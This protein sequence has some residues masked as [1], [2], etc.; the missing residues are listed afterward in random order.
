MTGAFTACASGVVLVDNGVSRCRVVAN[1]GAPPAVEFGARE[2]AKYLGKATGAKVEAGTRRADGDGLCQVEVRV[3]ASLPEESYAIDVDGKDV[4]VRGADARGVL[5]G[6]YELLKRWAGMRW[7]APGEDGEYCVLGGNTVEIPVGKY[8][9]GPDLK[10]RTYSIAT[11]EDFLWC[12]RNNMQANLSWRNFSKDGTSPRDRRLMEL[13]VYGQGRSGHCLTR[14]LCH[15]SEDPKK[16]F[17]EHPEYFCLVKGKRVLSGLACYGPNP[18]TSN[19]EVLDRMAETVLMILDH[20]HGNEAA[21]VTIGNDDSMQWCECE[22]CKAL[23]PAET[24]S[25]GKRRRADR[26]WRMVNEIARRVWAKRP[27]A[28]LGGWAYQDFWKP[29][30]KVKPDSRLSLVIS[31]NNQ[32]WRHSI[33][34]PECDVNRDLAA[35]YRMWKPLKMRLV[36]NRNEFHC[37]GCPGG[38]FSPVERTLAGNFAQSEALRC[39]GHSFAGQGPFPDPLPW[40]AKSPDRYP[41]YGGKNMRWWACWQAHY[42]AARLMWD[43]S[44]DFAAELEEANSLMYGS[45]WQGGMKEFR[46]TLVKAFYATPGCQRWPDS[47]SIAKCLD[48]PGAEKKLRA[49]LARALEGAAKDPDPRVLNNV[50]RVEFIFGRTWLLEREKYLRA[51]REYEFFALTNGWNR[52][53]PITVAENVY[54]KGAYDEDALRLKV[55]SKAPI[56]IVAR[57]PGLT[58]AERR[59]VARERDVKI[60]AKDLGGKFLDGTSVLFETCGK[61][62]AVT[63]RPRARVWSTSMR[64][65]PVWLDGALDRVDPK[66]GG[67]AGW[68]NPKGAAKSVLY[69]G[70]ESNRFARL[71]VDASEI[72]NAYYLPAV[73]AGGY[74]IT[75]RARGKGRFRMWCASYRHVGGIDGYNAIVDGTAKAEEKALGD[76]WKTYSLV[77]KSVGAEMEL[78][79]IRFFRVGDGEFDIDD[80][81][82]EPLDTRALRYVNIV[83]LNPGHVDFTVSEARR[84]VSLGIRE[85]AACLSYGPQCLPPGD[86]L[87]KYAEAFRAFKAGLAGTGAKAGVLIQST[88]GHAARMADVPWQRVVTADGGQGARLCLLDPGFRAYILDTVRSICREK[89]AFLL[90]DDDF[91]PRGGEGFCPLHAALYNKETGESRDGLQWGA[92][93]RGAALDDPLRGK[94]ESLR[95]RVPVDFACAV[96]EAIDS[97]DPSIRCGYCLPGAGAGFAR[98]VALAFAGPGT[99]PFMRFNNAVYG[100]NPPNV[101]LGQLRT[102]RRLCEHFDGVDEFLAENDTWPHNYWS[103]SAKMFSAHLLL[104]VLHGLDG[105]KLWMSE[106]DSPADVGS[107]ARYERAFRDGLWKRQALYDVIRTEGPQFHGTTAFVNLPPRLSDPVKPETPGYASGLDDVFGPMGFPCNFAKSGLTHPHDVYVLVR[108]SVDLLSDHEIEQVLSHRA[109]VDSQG[110]KALVRRG[111]G[112][113]LCVEVSDYAPEDT[114]NFEVFAD[115]EELAMQSDGTNVRL[116]AASGAETLSRFVRVDR[117]HGGRVEL[118]AGLTLGRNARGG[119][120]MVAGWTYDCRGWNR[121]NKYLRPVRKERLVKAIDRLAGGVMPYVCVEDN[122]AQSS[123]ATLADGSELVVVTNLGGDDWADLALRRGSPPKAASRLDDRGEWQRVQFS[124]KDNVVTFRTGPV[125]PLEPQVLRVLPK[126][127]R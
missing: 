88:Q 56:E 74:R 117:V 75:C 69:E 41:P 109:F 1:E 76:E 5:Y 116:E 73:R 61:T 17:A 105:G 93:M 34:D 115:G 87:P 125:R 12:A 98:D 95:L 114:F 62:L 4:S 64:E 59:I 30:L 25:D 53:V 92:F 29:P 14:L 52:A 81:Y 23:D 126:A 2:I 40:E 20:P 67:P 44:R 90:V 102:V 71:G 6:C 68:S 107:Q 47:I 77:T 10:W 21:T 111:F 124:W 104:G 22:A 83:P 110:A 37:E 39:D 80:V 123:Y 27:D 28:K 108:N 18:C 19:P 26:Y 13:A 60:S 31:F 122:H 113:D 89:P 97:V 91:G 99:R 121:W 24:A 100:M 48:V 70:S 118:G 120:V 65:L 45:A 96:R 94:I 42:M 119:L 49:S 43:R 127:A 8:A 38:T 106:F 50:R 63:L 103:E 16:L 58:P 36:V 3:D 46:E 112:G 66:T 7:L 51:H 35:L 54:L 79:S 101:L 86:L 85:F 72:G 84:Q 32:C 11:D 78:L 15:D 33:D 55:Y 82:V 57:R 9:H